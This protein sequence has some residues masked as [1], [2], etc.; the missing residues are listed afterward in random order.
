MQLIKKSVVQNELAQQKKQQI[1]EGVKIAG[2]VDL[3]RRTLADLEDQQ[4]KFIEK[5]RLELEK[6]TKDLHAQVEYLK[7][8]ILHLEDKREKLLK[9]LEEALTL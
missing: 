4:T 9:S 2:K 3:L 1:D 6:Q 8:E 7:K 5:S